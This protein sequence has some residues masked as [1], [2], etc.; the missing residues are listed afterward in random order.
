MPPVQHYKNELIC[1]VFLLVNCVT[2]TT[3]LILQLL[4]SIKADNLYYDFI[5]VS[6]DLIKLYPSIPI[7]YDTKSILDM[8][9]QYWNKIN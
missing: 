4:T 8:T 5:F 3:E 6:S 7:V 2:N 1:K 9:K